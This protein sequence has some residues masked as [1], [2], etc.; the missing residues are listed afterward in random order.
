M[1]GCPQV[2][3]VHCGDAELSF[4]KMVR[5]LY[6][7]H[8]MEGVP[9]IMWRD[10]E[11]EVRYAGRAPNF[12]DMNNTPLPDF[13]EYFYARK[14]SGYEASPGSRE[15]LLPFE[16][17][18]GCWWG[19]KHHCTFCGLN[20]SGMEFRAK[21]ADK[22]VEQLDVLSRRYGQLQF[23]AIDNIMAPEYTEKLFG[24]LIGGCQ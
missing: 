19:E 12:I 21:D 3:Y 23:N 16:A 14:A 18:R 9:G 17:A 5:R 4:P 15:P 10:G 22:V 11:G 2:D 8:S 1:K 6:A 24:K 7:G 13:D 20:R